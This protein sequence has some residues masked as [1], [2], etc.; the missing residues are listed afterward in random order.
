MPYSVVSASTRAD[1][2]AAIATFASSNGWT[3]EYNVTGELGLS[4]LNCH[5]ALSDGGTVSE[6]DQINGGTVT[7]GFIFGALGSSLTASNH[8]YYGHPDSVVT[9]SGD[10]D[11]VT[12]N[13]LA[14]PFSNVYLFTDS[15]TS[16]TYIHV[17]VQSS[18]G[19]YT[20]FS[21]GNVNKMGFSHANVGYLIGC[22]YTWWN[23]YSNTA[24]A[25]FYPNNIAGIHGLW[26]LSRPTYNAYVPSGVLDTAL[27]FP[28]GVQMLGSATSNFLMSL[29]NT[30]QS[31]SAAVG[32][33]L[34]HFHVSE[35]EA[36]TG[37]APMW[38]LP[39]IYSVSDSSLRCMLGMLPDICLFSM[40]GFSP[41]EVVAYGTENWQIFPFKSQGSH[42]NS[43]TGINP[44]AAVNT[45][46]FAL[47]I[48][49]VA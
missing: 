45:E 2:L 5:V 46:N 35:N 26:I 30:T 37:G 49:Q 39:C 4:K 22:N 10:S 48:K 43:N 16:S 18:T 25:L 15:S 44:L 11:R 47:A 7:D 24:S 31:M 41:V 19:R 34:D 23:N 1:L 12:I 20:T 9:T 3:V 27:G 32:S 6:S 8:H 14:G 21:F 33:P 40:T 42:A 38:P 29:L 36:T 13:D 17:V 28:S